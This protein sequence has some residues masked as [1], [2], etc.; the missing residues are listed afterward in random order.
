VV[1]TAGSQSVTLR[2]QRPAGAVDVIIVRRPGRRGAESTVYE[3]T[4]NTYVDRTVRDRVPYRYLII[5][6]DSS[7]RLSSGVPTVVTPGGRS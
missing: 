3:G 1:V 6:R 2:W 7:G 4:R 5:S